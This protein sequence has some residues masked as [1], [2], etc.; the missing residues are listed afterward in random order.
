MNSIDLHF[1]GMDMNTMH[2]ICVAVMT[3]RVIV[4]RHSGGPSH[5]TDPVQIAAYLQQHDCVCMPCR[6]TH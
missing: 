1:N 6:H 2:V 5:R 3:V 4:A